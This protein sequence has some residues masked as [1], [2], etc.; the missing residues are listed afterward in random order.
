MAIYPPVR[1]QRADSRVQPEDIAD[2]LRNISISVPSMVP[3]RASLPPDEHMASYPTSSAAA[4]GTLAETAY[5]R[6]NTEPIRRDSLKRREALLRG[7]EGSR[8]R[9]RWENGWYLLQTSAKAHDVY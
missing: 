1:S 9:Q 6:R 8:R 3:L 2:T 4:S 5:G 7:R